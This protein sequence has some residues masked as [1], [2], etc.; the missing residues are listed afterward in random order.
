MWHQWFKCNTFLCAKNTKK[1][2]YSKIVVFWML[3]GRT[4]DVLRHWLK[5]RRPNV[6]EL[7]HCLMCEVMFMKVCYDSNGLSLMRL[8]RGRKW[9]RWHAR[10][11]HLRWLVWLLP[12]RTG[13]ER[14]VK[15]WRAAKNRRSYMLLCMSELMATTNPCWLGHFSTTWSTL[16]M[17]C[18]SVAYLR[19]LLLPLISIIC[20]VLKRLYCFESNLPWSEE[21]SCMIVPWS[22][23][24]CVFF[25]AQD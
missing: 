2:L 8:Y 3:C 20:H 24:I 9:E 6:L 15:Q 5:K 4:K 18:L 14:E 17:W 22:H 1:W 10:D 12:L 7:C 11:R 23:S 21:R 19:C 16:L 25:I 13:D